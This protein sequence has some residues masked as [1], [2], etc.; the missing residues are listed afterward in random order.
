MER[1]PGPLNDVKVDRSL[2]VVYL[3]F[4]RSVG[5]LLRSGQISNK[6][7]SILTTLIDSLPWNSRKL[8]TLAIGSVERCQSFMEFEQWCIWTAWS[9]RGTCRFTLTPLYKACISR[10]V[11]TFNNMP[12]FNIFKTF[13]SSKAPPRPAPIITKDYAYTTTPAAVRTPLSPTTVTPTP[14]HSRSASMPPEII[15]SEPITDPS[16]MRRGTLKKKNKHRHHHISEDTPM[17]WDEPQ[18]A[19]RDDILHGTPP[20]T[21]RQSTGLQPTNASVYPEEYPYP[22]EDHHQQR[23]QYNTSIGHGALPSSG[24]PGYESGS[25]P[26]MYSEPPRGGVYPEQERRHHSQHRHR[27]H[28]HHYQPPQQYEYEYAAPSAHGQGHSHNTWGP[29]QSRSRS[30]SRSFTPIP[31]VYREPDSMDLDDSYADPLM[32]DNHAQT[33]WSRRSGHGLDGHEPDVH[34]PP[35]SQPQARIGWIPSA[36]EQQMTEDQRAAHDSEPTLVGEVEPQVITPPIESE[37]PLRTN[38][39]HT[40]QPDWDPNAR[41]RWRTPA[42]EYAHENRHRDFREPE[43]PRKKAYMYRD[44]HYSETVEVGTTSRSVV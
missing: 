13:G 1:D 23:F 43:E 39:Y 21:A 34:G 44:Y 37:N 18:F 20:L 30:R 22:Y 38:V 32:R 29:D 33:S 42:Q 17:Q 16:L 31:S 26:A 19:P 4:Q 10:A 14:A 2:V 27:H 41:H 40:R 9:P 36:A 5:L 8:G 7:N 28:R 3:I 12:S 15:K 11:K 6:I 25:P 35:H 24:M